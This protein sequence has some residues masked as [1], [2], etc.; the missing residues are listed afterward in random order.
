MIVE[1]HIPFRLI[2]GDL[3]S[4]EFPSLEIIEAGDGEEA[5]RK[6]ESYLPDL[7]FMNIR[8]PGQNGLELTR[9]IKGEH[10]DI[11]IIIVT[12]N[13]LQEYM[14]AAFRYGANGF[15]S[16]DHLIWEEISTVVKC[17]Q[18]AKENGRKPACIRFSSG[19]VSI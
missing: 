3:L 19:E 4:H 18:E 8:L 15:I 2:L 16:K 17:H 11:T 5:L 12:S 13:D 1:D 7:I 10:P 9:K 6:L 14:E